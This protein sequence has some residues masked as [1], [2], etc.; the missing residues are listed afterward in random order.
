M[1]Y[2]IKKFLNK[3]IFLNLNITNIILCNCIIPLCTADLGKNLRF[4]NNLSNKLLLY[5]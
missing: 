1:I 5:Y 3:Y 4:I 2:Y